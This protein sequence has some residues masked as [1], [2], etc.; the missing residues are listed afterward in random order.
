MLEIVQ[1][2]VREQDTSHGLGALVLGAVSNIAG[3]EP[4]AKSR[5][6]AFIERRSNSMHEV[7]IEMEVMHRDQAK[8]E[9]FFRFG[10]V[11]DVSAREG[12][13]SGAGTVFFDRTLVETVGVVL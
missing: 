1:K 8:A 4:L 13:A 7:Q 6:R 12:P 2:V 9:D 5:K 10:Q 11:P 3:D